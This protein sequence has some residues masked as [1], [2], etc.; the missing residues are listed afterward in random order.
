MIL[1]D[2]DKRM[3]NGEFGNGMEKCMSLLVKWGDLFGAERMVNTDVVHISTNFPTSAI[4][5]MTEG[6]KTINAFCTTHS[7]FDPKYWREN[8]NVVVEN[9]AGGYATTKEKEFQ[10]RMTVLKRLGV[11]GTF[12]CSPYTV[13]VVPRYGDVMSMMGSS[14]QVI[15]NS[16]FGAR[17]PRE[18]ISTSFAAAVTGRTPEMGLVRKVERCATVLIKIGNDVDI[19]GFDE[20]DF[21][22]LGYYLGGVAESQNIAIEGIS[23]GLTLEHGRMLVSPLPVSGACVMCHIV[24]VTPEA[25][26]LAQCTGGRKPEVEIEVKRRNIADGYEKLNNAEDPKLDMVVLGCPHLTIKEIKDLAALMD[27]NR[28]SQN[29]RVVVGIAKGAYNLAKECGFSDVIEAAGGILVNCCVSGLNPYIFLENEMRA[30]VVA[31]NSARAAHY[32]QRLS[33]GETKTFYSSMKACIN[34]A[35]KGRWNRQ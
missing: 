25:T 10:E 24:G 6:V 20:A 22:A 33:K 23:S 28:I 29:V 15:S 13:G 3:L 8:L 4:M 2:N 14:G 35:V 27:G 31:T 7:V 30:R 1:S 9:M 12:T 34:S 21:G 26:C 19:N 5:E 11:L 16:F 32:I 18:S 17:A